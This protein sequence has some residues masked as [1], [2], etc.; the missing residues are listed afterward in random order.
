MEMLIVPVDD[1]EL[2][3]RAVPVAGSLAV[4][5]GATVA[6]LTV[7]SA[8]VDELPEQAYLES[9]RDRLPESVDVTTLVRL[10]D[11]P[12]DEVIV[13][14]A[15]SSPDAV[16]VMASHGRRALAELVL[17]STG[18]AV[19]RSSPVPVVVV[20]PHC[21]VT[22]DLTRPVIV[23]VD[24]SSIDERVLDAAAAWSRATGAP[25]RVV[26]VRVPVAVDGGVVVTGGDDVAADAGRRLAA[27]GADVRWND[28]SA[29]DAGQG[30]LEA[31]V[32]EG[33]GAM[34]VGTRRAGRVA[35]A[36]MGSVATDVVHRATVP[37][38]VTS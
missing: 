29:V 31:A 15:R 23:G 2:S 19:I 6:L 36:L 30:L 3:E 24:G 1:T 28:H 10:V 27:C 7:D 14:A 12:V 38:V 37:V 4:L 35:T 21:D 33:A 34:V 8:H 18:E 22:V 25:L 13:E 26:H 11:R 17:G 16:I 32:D 20:G 9:V 5:A